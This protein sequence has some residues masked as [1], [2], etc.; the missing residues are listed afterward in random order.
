MDRQGAN[1]KHTEGQDAG[2]VRE[3]F[4]GIASR[5]VL[6]NHVLS[7]GTDLWWRRRTAALV[8][9]MRP[10]LVLDLATGSGDLAKAIQRACPE[11]RVL[12]MDFS[13][14]MMRVSQQSGFQNL[15]AADAMH[16]PVKDSAL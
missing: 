11:A 14:P 1:R 5:Y 15:I 8:A 7:L 12:G 16:L 9:E 10:R 2:Y 13:V 4:A 6:T 3:A